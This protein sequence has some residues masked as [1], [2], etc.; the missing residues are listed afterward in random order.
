MHRL[1]SNLIIYGNISE[2]SI[3][4]RL[5]GIFKRLETGASDTE[6]LAGEVRHE[7]HR[8]LG[9]ATDYAFD[10]DLWRDYIAYLL[11]M[12]EN[13]FTL[14]CEK[15]GAVD[16]SVNVFADSDMAVFRQLLDFDF[17]VIEKKLGLNCFSVI[18]DYKAVPKSDAACDRNASRRIRELSRELKDTK[19]VDDLKDVLMAF[20]RHYGVGSFGMNKAFRIAARDGRVKIIP[21]TAA[22]DATFADITGYEAQKER[23]RKNTES[24]LSGR[25]ANN[26]LLYG[27]AG[28]GKSTCIKA[29]LNEYYERGLRIIEVYKHDFP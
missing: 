24:F 15:T 9:L 18:R 20:Y 19:G 3:L 10:E 13:P 7:I 29:L 16:G 11:A 25:P 17:S 23:L 5:A 21:I 4:H 6:E 28:T 14:A 27:D 2:D 1:V 22:G 12:T 8:L 26:V